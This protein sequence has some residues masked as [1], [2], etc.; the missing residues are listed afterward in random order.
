MSRHVSVEGGCA[1]G[2]GGGRDPGKLGKG[3]STCGADQVSAF[4]PKA[5]IVL[6]FSLRQSAKMLGFKIAVFV[7]FAFIAGC[8]RE[9]TQAQRSTQDGETPRDFA[10]LT[11]EVVSPYS[12]GLA[13]PEHRVVQSREEWE[14]LWRELEPR[15][16][17]KQ[18]QTLPNPVPDID[19][20]RNVLIVAAMGTR[21][22]GGYSV[23]IPSL[24]ESSNRIVVTV[25]EKSPGPKCGT[26]QAITHPIAIVTTARTE[27]PFEFEFVRTT[28]QCT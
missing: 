10:M 6:Q 20:Q 11:G 5:D 25:A 1:D 26:A 15:T 4:D 21:P 23:E 27:K 7:T 16:S 8:G 2:V 24:E 3:V 19:F 18:G 12:G 13:Q 14:E 22:N 9:A 17:R 28:Q